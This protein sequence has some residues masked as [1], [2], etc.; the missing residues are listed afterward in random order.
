MLKILLVSNNQGYSNEIKRSAILA[1]VEIVAHFPSIQDVARN[2]SKLDPDV[3]LAS[4]VLFPGETIQNL[5]DFVKSSGHRTQLY[6]VLKDATY[7]DYLINKQIPYVFEND[8][9]PTELLN[10]LSAYC[11]DSR[12]NYNERDIESMETKNIANILSNEQKNKERV[13]HYEEQIRGNQTPGFGFNV[14]N[15]FKNICVAINSP[16]GGVG[17]TTIAIELATMLAAR[18]KELDLNPASKLNSTKNVNVC[19]IDFNPSFDTMASTLDCVRRIQNYPTLTDWVSKIEEKIFNTL[20]EETKKSILQNANVD[21]SHYI[22]ERQIKFTRE[23]V[24]SLLVNDETTGLYIL[25]SVS[26]PFDVEYV[27]PEYI[28]IIIKVVKAMF[29][30]VLIDTGNNISYYT[31]EALQAADEIFVISTASKAS[32][33]VI[34]KLLKNLDKLCLDSSKFNLVINNA[35]GKFSDLDA[36][37]I[38]NV[39]KLTLISELPYDEN[40]KKSHEAGYPFSIFNKKTPYSREIAK[41]AQQIAPLWN[42]TNKRSA[43]GAPKIKKGFS[44]FKK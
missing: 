43:G 36:S 40:V 12:L 34:G 25:P 41:L 5:I 33:V 30:I 13:N 17:K 26:L 16:K 19:L 35:Y 24:L 6:F 10:R 37:T 28:Q 21:F 42:V 15:N 31:V 3:V 4:D 11:N 20:P 9:V 1:D 18:A 23:E 22:D 14:V 32:S 44:L 7:A 27:K 2:L 39:L 8:V 29:D 38:A